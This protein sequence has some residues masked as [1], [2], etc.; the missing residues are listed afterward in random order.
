MKIL[1]LVGL[2]VTE[3]LFY[4]LQDIGDTTIIRITYKSVSIIKIT[5][6]EV[7]MKQIS[8]IVDQEV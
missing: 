8:I 3:V 5:V 6:L 1:S 2:N 7:A 4:Y